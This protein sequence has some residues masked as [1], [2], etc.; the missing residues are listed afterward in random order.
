MR[1]VN[2]AWRG[3]ETASQRR[4]V[5]LAVSRGVL[6]MLDRSEALDGVCRGVALREGVTT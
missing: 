3:V 6:T 5:L 1:R 4:V 2:V